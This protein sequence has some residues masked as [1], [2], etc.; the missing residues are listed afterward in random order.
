MS[1]EIKAYICGISEKGAT[2]FKYLETMMSEQKAIKTT[3]CYKIFS[4]ISFAHVIIR[5]TVDMFCLL[6]FLNISQCI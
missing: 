1:C 3:A 6:K 5:A 4:V 2:L